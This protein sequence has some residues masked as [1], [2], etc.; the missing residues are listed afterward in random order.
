MRRRSAPGTPIGSTNNGNIFAARITSSR[1]SRLLPRAFASCAR[2]SK[3]V[4]D[5]KPSML[6]RL[7]KRSAAVPS[8]ICNASWPAI[9][10]KPASL[11][12][13]A[14]A[15]EMISRMSFATS[16]SFASINRRVTAGARPMPAGGKDFDSASRSSRPSCGSSLSRICRRN[17][18][19]TACREAFTG[20]SAS[21]VWRWLFVVSCSP[22]KRAAPAAFREA[23]KPGI[24]TIRLASESSAPFALGVMA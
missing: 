3:G 1:C 16:S 2:P 23:S 13:F 20:P 7:R 6:A 21:A 19:Q 22:A 5:G 24:M 11:G 8:S 4:G 14:T 15:F 18:I 10:C 12:F 9:N 17:Q